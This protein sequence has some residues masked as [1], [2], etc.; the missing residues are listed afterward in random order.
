M[1]Q[2]RIGVWLV[3]IAALL[4]TLDAPF[5]KFLTEGLSSATIVFMEHILIGGLVLL[6]LFKYLPELKNL[7]WKEWLAV[8]FIAI[9]GSALATI[10]FTQSF[11]YVNPSVA[12]LLQKVQPFVAIAFAALFLKERLTK[13]F[14]VWAI[15]AIFGAYLLTFPEFKITGLSF[16]GGSL[17]VMFA[18]LAAV[19]WGGS[20]VFGRYV[21]R[22]ISFQAMTA[23][24][25]LTA[26]LFLFF[27]QLYYGALGEVASA[28]GKD[29]LFVLII[30]VI[31][32]FIS[33]F[34][35][36]K[37]LTNTKAS[38]ATLA[39]LAFPFSA[40]LVNWIFLDATLV[41]GQI[42]GGVVLLI[43]IVGLSRVNEQEA[44]TLQS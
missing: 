21:L 8:G 36:Y 32:G 16:A 26:L 7:S 29:W 11:R 17:G 6:F 13:R 30:A 22:K 40:V 12:I 2:N 44:D 34:I 20:T 31:V 18:L 9:G 5:R 24:R 41:V 1:N 39:E 28:T 23:V 10:F 14:W 4:W 42:A 27:V 38:I 3:F 37:G 15:L 25:F 33:L 35:Y 19:L 43:A